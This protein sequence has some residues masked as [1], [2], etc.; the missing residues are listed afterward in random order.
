MVERISVAIALEGGKEVERQL[1]DIGQAGQKAFADISKSAEQVG[2]FKNL[3]ADEVTK[4]LQEFGVTGA[5]AINKIQTAVKSASQLESIVQGIGAVES[6]FLGIAEAAAIVGAAV[7]AA[8]VALSRYTSEA[9]KVA[10][11]LRPLADLS[12]QAFQS[13]SALQIAFAQGG[14]AAQKFAEEFTNLQTKVSEAGITMADD[15]DK[16]SQR[17][18]QAQQAVRQAAA[19]VAQAQ[20]KAHQS[21]LN[22]ANAQLNLQQAQVAQR[23]QLTGLADPGAEKRL[24]DAR[25]ILAVQEAQQRLDTANVAQQRLQQ[26][27]ATDRVKLQEAKHQADVAEANDLAVIIGLYQ[28]M[29]EGAKIAF[30]PLT[31]QA[32]KN[33]ALLAALA[34][35]GDNYT[36]VLADILKNASAL[37][38]VQI[39]KALALDPKTIE[40]LSQGSTA[41]REQQQAVESLGLAL[42]DVDRANLKAFNDSW[43]KLGATASAAMEKLGA[44]L[45]PIGTLIAQGLLVALE[46][47]IREVDN[48]VSDVSKIGTEINNAATLGAAGIRLL[49]DA[50]KAAGTAIGD[51]ASLL[52]GITWGT[53]ADAAVAAWNQVLDVINK[54]IAAVQQFI[55]LAPSAAPAASGGGGGGEGFARG[56]LLGGRGSGTSDSNLAWVSRGEHIMPAAAV[57]QPGVLAF[58]EALRLTGGNLR[59]V[60]DGMGRFA[61][62]GLVRG[63]IPAFA[64]GGMVGGH[65]GTLTLGLPSGDSVTVRATSGVVD[66]L[67]KEAALAQ[68]RSGGRKPSRYS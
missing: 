58:L 13:V 52:S 33:K 15:I 5:E 38:R 35:A 14:T 39:G 3:N 47:V 22:I 64:G 51:F 8:T 28:R 56:G 68:V 66:Q 31:E 6:A 19:G 23:R 37:E 17:I 57:R 4:K 45:A 25:A 42:T 50:I 67:R 1:E 65:L 11:Q 41:L 26:R 9:A 34:Q 49:V 24:A 2:G 61:L 7:I 53:F 48:L 21:E 60:F 27:T 10:E 18:V 54:A 20:E 29:A 16:S 12:G 62:G 63:P 59:A 32:T 30:D 46:A 55:G 36:F 40:T 44:A 43:S